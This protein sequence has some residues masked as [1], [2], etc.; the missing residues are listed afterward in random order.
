MVVVVVVVVVQLPKNAMDRD[1]DIEQLNEILCYVHGN[2]LE[3]VVFINLSFQRFQSQSS[4]ERCFFVRSHD[5]EMDLGVDL[6]EE[7]PLARD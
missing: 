4:S 5:L 7:G 1:G 6:P 2:L 3:N